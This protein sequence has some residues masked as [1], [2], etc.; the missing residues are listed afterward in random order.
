MLKDT[1]QKTAA[2]LG[3]GSAPSSAAPS[4]RQTA[5]SSA[6]RSRPMSTASARAR[7]EWQD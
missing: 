5:V 7:P 3:L 1:R 4:R 6:P 2:S